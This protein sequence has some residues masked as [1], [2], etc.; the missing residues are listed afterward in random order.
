MVEDR[1]GYRYAKSVFELAEEKKLLDPTRE[2]MALLDELATNNREF[3]NLLESPLIKAG[4]KQAIMDRLFGDRF[5]SAITPL[6]V[7][8]VVRKS[9]EMYLPQVAKSFLSIY[10]TENGI[11]RGSLTSA[12]SLS[13][14]EQKEIQQA[15]E[16]KL[17]KRFVMQTEVDPELIGGF[18]LKFGDRLFDGSVASS[19]RRIKQELTN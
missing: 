10:D 2:D 1:I 8:M 12:V 6:L 11:V 14:A 18:V 3:R 16:K 9:R 7:A 4:A 5:Q 13:E 19:I 15:V 17:G